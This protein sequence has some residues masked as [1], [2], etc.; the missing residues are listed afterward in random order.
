MFRKPVSWFS[1]SSAFRS[2][3]PLVSVLD[4]VS[5]KCCVLLPPVCSD[6]P[7]FSWPY[8]SFPPHC[9]L[10]CVAVQMLR[11]FIITVLLTILYT[12][13]LNFPSPSLSPNIISLFMESELCIICPK[14]FNLLIVAKVSRECL[15]IIWFV[16]DAFILLNAHGIISILLSAF[17]CCTQTALLERL[18]S[19]AA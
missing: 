19:A 7:C 2:Q 6:I 9:T 18:L 8:K 3:V 11:Q 15:G 12:A 4:C 16:A 5:K 17:L 1:S 14:Y 10:F 13:F